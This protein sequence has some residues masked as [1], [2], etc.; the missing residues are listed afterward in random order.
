MNKTWILSVS[1]VDLLKH[2]LFIRLHFKL[3]HHS[4][5]F[6]NNTKWFFL[7]VFFFLVKMPHGMKWLVPTRTT[8]LARQLPKEIGKLSE[9]FPVCTPALDRNRLRLTQCLN[10]ACDPRFR[11]M[12]VRLRAPSHTRLRA[13]DH[14]TSSTLIGGKGGAGTSSLHTRLEGPTYIV[15]ACKMDVKSTWIPTWHQMDHVSWSLGFLLKTT[16]WRQVEHKTGR[17][18]HSKRSQLLIYLIL[19]CVK[20]R[21]NRNSLK[22]HLVEG[23]VHMTSHYTRGSVTSLHDFAGLLGRPL[24]TF[25]L[26]SHNFMV[27]GIGT[28]VKWPSWPTLEPDGHTRV[29]NIVQVS[30]QGLFLYK[31]IKYTRAAF[32]SWPIQK[33]R[34]LS[35]HLSNTTLL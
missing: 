17:P 6:H 31:L 8:I 3:E 34:G 23:P 33:T 15:C 2:F 20:I 24:N 5:I 1:L 26:G 32:P 27:T 10:Q 16:F 14:Y 19:S 28:C 9:G 25:L 11:Q 22:Q 18:W 12:C 7:F 4:A 29:Y 30:G 35:Y 13:R 21:M